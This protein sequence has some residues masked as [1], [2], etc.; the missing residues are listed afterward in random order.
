MAWRDFQM[1][2]KVEDEIFRNPPSVQKDQKVQK[3]NTEPPLNG[4]FVHIVLGSNIENDLAYSPDRRK[5]VQEATRLYRERGWVQIFSS[6]LNQIIYLVMDPG[7]K[8]PDSSIPK[9]LQQEIDALKGLTLD[10]L[11][12]LHEAKK[13]FGGSISYK[14]Q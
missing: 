2:H 8:V 10:E 6:Y 9:Y 11:K 13:I 14:G 7:I 5:S 1:P 12:T 3:E 4:H